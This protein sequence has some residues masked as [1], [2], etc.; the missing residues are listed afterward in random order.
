MRRWCWMLPLA[1]CAA[2]GEPVAWLDGFDFGWVDFNHRLTALHITPEADF[3][4]VAV[5]GGTSTT[6]V[7]FD[8]DGTCIG[9]GCGELP[10]TDEAD[11]E[12]RW[13]VGTPVDKVATGVGTIEVLA[14]PESSSARLIIDLPRR[15]K[16]T[17]VAFLGGLRL[18]GATD[19]DTANP[20]CYDPR[21]G[22]LPRRVAVELGEPVLADD[23]RSVTIEVGASFAAGVTGE[24]LRVCLDAAAPYAAMR[25]AIDVVVLVGEGETTTHA[26][27]TGGSFPRDPQGTQP[28][29]LDQTGYVPS[30][31]G[32]PVGWRKVD[33]RFHAS[34]P[35]QRG[36]YLRTL[37]LDVSP[38]EAL[39]YGWATSTSLTMTSGFEV[40][41]EGEV[42][43]ADFGVDVVHRR[44][45]G[46]ALPAEIDDEGT[47][48][49]H[50]LNP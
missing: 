18:D 16:G 8:D 28:I 29:P 48:I 22:W 45:D 12:V 47:P 36:T 13:S 3:A 43:E 21:H 31:D 14:V 49:E 24:D 10:L 25:A 32:A 35:D 50:V 19:G 26:V 17:A 2:P 44:A 11:V 9:P 39:L 46:D 38:D 42:V 15:A 41:F 6:G 5:I 33:W 23:G 40:A 20:S 1:G 4:R 34:D 37:D 30:W 7:V 27:T